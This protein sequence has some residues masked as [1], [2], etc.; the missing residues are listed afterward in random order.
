[1]SNN[2]PNP[3]GVYDDMVKAGCE[4][5]SWASDLY[6]R[7]T[8]EAREILE[9]HNYKVPGHSCQPFISNIAPHVQWFDVPFAYQP[10]WDAVAKRSMPRGE[11]T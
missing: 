11:P 5:A 8:P 2:Y 3:V 9:A 10:Y 6:V 1:M 4:I 7:D